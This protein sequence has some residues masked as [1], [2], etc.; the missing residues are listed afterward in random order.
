M[1]MGAENPNDESECSY[2]QFDCSFSRSRLT[3]A[4][5]NIEQ[6]QKI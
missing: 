2:L 3:T 4:V 6:T 5:Q 1:I